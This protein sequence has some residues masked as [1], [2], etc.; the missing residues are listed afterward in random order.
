MEG[1]K[2][3]VI[4]LIILLILPVLLATAQQKDLA[5]Y[6][7]AFFE[8]Y[9]AGDMAPWPGLIAEM[10]QAHSTDLAWQTEMV[11]ALYGLVGYQI[12]ARKKDL[13]KLYVDKADVYLDQLLNDH[14]TNA[15]LH[16]LASAFYGYKISFAFYKAPFLGPKSLYHIHKAIEL[17]PNEPMGYIEKG[18]SLL[19]RP[20]ALGGDK[21]EAL[22][23]YRKALQLMQSHTTLKCDWQQMLLR[24][25]ILKCLYE[26]NQTVEA[27]A[28]L[29]SMQ[30]DYGSMI[31]IKSFVGINLMEGK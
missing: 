20:A 11:K 21:M 25:F 4:G 18:N 28:F 15:Q 16:S 26:T 29:L 22:S 19:Y 2:N 6:Q 7:C 10:E 14:P 31:W 9:K 8:S 1:T 23:L 30:N 13:A 12:G 3:K 27:N 17:D 24:A 5:Y